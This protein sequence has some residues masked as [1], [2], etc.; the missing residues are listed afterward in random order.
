MGSWILFALGHFSLHLLKQHL[1]SFGFICSFKPQFQLSFVSPHVC[2]SA[3]VCI[4]H[5]GCSPHH[6]FAQRW[7]QLL[8]LHC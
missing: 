4:H 3:H 5:T 6:L 2:L 8:L 1:L 7:E